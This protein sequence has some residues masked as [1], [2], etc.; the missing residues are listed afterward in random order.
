MHPAVGEGPGLP[1]DIMRSRSEI[2]LCSGLFSPIYSRVKCICTYTLLPFC[3]FCVQQ[4]F[5]QRCLSS[6]LLL[7]FIFLTCDLVYHC[8]LF[9]EGRIK[10]VCAWIYIICRSADFTAYDVNKD[11]I[12]LY[13]NSRCVPKIT[14]CC[15]LPCANLF[16]FKCCVPVALGRWLAI[17]GSTEQSHDHLLLSEICFASPAQR[18]L[19]KQGA[20][21]LTPWWV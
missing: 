19:T 17:T 5:S 6:P 15:V 11:R 2:S 4:H 16:V 1:C 9:S 18:E 13:T 20:A 8:S 3:A 14:H 10:P 12:W 21:C 7:L